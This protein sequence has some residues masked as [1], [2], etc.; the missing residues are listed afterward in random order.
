M[1]LPAAAPAQADSGNINPVPTVMIQALMIKVNNTAEM[2][3]PVTITVF[4]RRSNETIAGA[5]VYAIKTSGRV[6]PADPGNYTT[7]DG[8]L[9]ALTESDGI[10]IGTTGSDGTVL[11]NLAEAGRYLL[12]ATKDGFIPGFAR[13][14]VKEDGQKGRLNLQA[15]AS[16]PTG[17]QVTIRVTYGI[18]G[19]AVE[20]ATVSA[21]KTVNLLPP[22]IKPAPVPTENGTA[23]QMILDQ[24]AYIMINPDQ[25]EIL[26]SQVGKREI[27]LGSSNSAGEVSYTFKDPGMYMLL[28]RKDGYLPGARRINIQP[29]TALRSLNIKVVFNPAP[30]Q[31]TN[32]LVTEKSSDQPVAG[33][34]VYSL[35]VENNKDIKQMPLTAN[36]LKA[37]IVWAWND[38]DRAREKGV[39]VGNTDSA[40]Q[41]SY[42]FP[43]PGQYILAA[44]KDGYTTAVTRVSYSQPVFGK[45]LHLK[46]PA[47]ANAGGAVNVATYDDNGTAVSRAAIY[48]VRLDSIKEGLS[49]LNLLP[50]LTTD[51]KEKYM[52]LLRDKSLLSG[53]TDENGQISVKFAGPGI[54]LLLAV[55]DGFIPDFAKIN[56]LQVATVTT[57]PVPQ[58]TTTTTKEQ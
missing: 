39:P 13:L 3:Q 58:A 6:G 14:Q 54:F 36:N 22:T 52:P 40:G 30:G 51:V 26:A 31:P 42:S 35:K 56:I 28:V 49:L 10:L 17:Q 25:A 43:S 1:A 57:A 16:F 33:A 24:Q 20:N 47:E 50:G 23:T 55:K 45:A 27:I 44:F 12:V 4:S 5:P 21:F 29:D 38:A 9:E 15:P 19:Q 11:A 46:A 34:A 53:Y 18:S 32:I 7:L 48:S 37:P 2:G 41:T 8:E